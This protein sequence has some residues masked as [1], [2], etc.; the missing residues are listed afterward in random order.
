MRIEEKIWWKIAATV[1]KK[2]NTL[3]N[4]RTNSRWPSDT[5]YDVLS[6]HYLSSS[7]LNTT[8]CCDTRR[9]PIL[10]QIHNSLPQVYWSEL[11]R[12]NQ[13]HSEDRGE[14]NKNKKLS[15]LL[16]RVEEKKVS[17]IRTWWKVPDSLGLLCCIRNCMNWIVRGHWR[18]PKH[19]EDGYV[20]EDDDSKHSLENK[21]KQEVMFPDVKKNAARRIFKSEKPD[22]V[23]K[24]LQE[25]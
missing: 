17:S 7:E 25:L 13:N 1:V 11:I 8:R 19:S 2:K 3:I 16:I 9:I 14:E 23:F 21:I 5:R 24:I 18:I 10:S 12:G 20:L 15:R 6:S 4:L 22:Q